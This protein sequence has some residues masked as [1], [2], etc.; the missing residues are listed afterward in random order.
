MTL[1]TIFDLSGYA[2]FVTGGGTHIGKSIA[3][4]FLDFGAEV[5]IGSRRFDVCAKTAKE[6]VNRGYNCVPHYCDAAE[7]TSVEEVVGE[8]VAKR[9]RLDIMVCNAGAASAG[10]QVPNIS[11]DR[12]AET[13][14]ASATS[15]FVSA[16]VAARQMLEQ[17]SGSIVLIG[18]IFGSLGANPEW[19]G[20][21]WSRS[22]SDYNAAK[23]AVVALARSMACELGGHGIRV[24]SI[25][26]G[27]IPYSD[28]DEYTVEK[29]RTAN[30]LKRTGGPDDLRGIAVLLASAAGAFITGQDFRVDGGWSAW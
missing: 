8:I 9:G 5:H 25:S 30:P 7:E 24:N 29:F 15:A 10:C 20:P 4:A 21:G 13:I 22:C 1:K 19:Y 17:D 12:W 2:A 16:Q 14:R 18:S 3:S 28:S 26:P 11:L 23:G 27:Q 6:F